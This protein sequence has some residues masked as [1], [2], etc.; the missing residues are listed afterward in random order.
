M[1]ASASTSAT[2]APAKRARVVSGPPLAPPK[3]PNSLTLSIALVNN[4]PMELGDD[5][6]LPDNSNALKNIFHTIN[7]PPGTYVDELDL[8][9][10]ANHLQK[11]KGF[12]GEVDMLDVVV[13]R[14]LL[15][16]EDNEW[17]MDE[18]IFCS[19]EGASLPAAHMF[20]KLRVYLWARKA[21]KRGGN[22]IRSMD[23]IHRLYKSRSFTWV[24]LLVAAWPP[25]LAFGPDPQ[26]SA[27]W[28]FELDLRRGIELDLLHTLSNRIGVKYNGLLFRAIN[29]TGEPVVGHWYL[30]LAKK[31]ENNDPI[32]DV[33]YITKWLKD[34]MHGVVVE[35]SVWFAQ[36]CC[37]RWQSPVLGKVTEHDGG[38][39]PLLTTFNKVR[40]AAGLTPITLS[41]NKVNV[42]LQ[43]EP[44]KVE[45]V[46]KENDKQF[47]ELRGEVAALTKRVAAL[48][49][50]AGI[51]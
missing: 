14:T 17:A 7:S 37:L 5:D 49:K 24:L 47:K 51:K 6:E 22:L 18:L 32:L 31:N 19:F 38:H 4:A 41:Q 45:T 30:C 12:G 21:S 43:K 29:K 48:E 36:Q 40:K 16:H 2:P 33:K 15:V 39:C 25:P 9:A 11:L 3:H 1:P 50:K 35:D 44:I 8:F 42:S 28:G 13:T 20:Y 34:H 23:P 26:S 27:L 46:A 10:M